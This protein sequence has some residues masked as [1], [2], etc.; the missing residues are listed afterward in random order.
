M[1]F[2]LAPGFHRL[3]AV[4]VVIAAVPDHHGAAAV[5]PFRDDSLERGVFNRM[6]LDFN[7]E[8]FFALSPRQTF[9]H[10]P[11]FQDA[12]H[13]ETEI[14]MQSPGV[15]LLDDKARRAFDFFRQRLATFWLGRFAKIAFRFVSL[16]A[17][18]LNLTAD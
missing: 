1:Q 2:P 15:M 18:R 16:Q 11:R 13:L 5:L 3:F 8:M 10:R 4:D 14:V 12:I 9:R 7:G 17:H 6:I